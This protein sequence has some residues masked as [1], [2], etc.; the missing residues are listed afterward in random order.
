MLYLILNKIMQNKLKILILLLSI[1]LIT[2]FSCDILKYNPSEQDNYHEIADA[3]I[4]T[5]TILIAEN[6]TML[7]WGEKNLN[8]SLDLQGKQIDSIICM[9]DS[10]IL[11]IDNNNNRKFI[12]LNSEQFSDG[13]HCIK[14]I[15]KMRVKSGNGSLADRF[16]REYFKV[17]SEQKFY[18][19]IVNYLPN[20][21][22]IQQMGVESGYLTIRWP[23]YSK[24]NFQEYRIYYGYS[25]Y[26]VKTINDCSITMYQD[27]LFLGGL[28]RYRIDIKVAD[29]IVQGIERNYSDEYPDINFISQVDSH[30]IEIKWNTSKYYAAYNK[31]I[32]FRRIKYNA[33]NEIY[34]T[35]NIN[36]TTF[37]DSIFIFGTQIQYRLGIYRNNGTGGMQSDWEDN[38]FTYGDTL[39]SFIDIDYIPSKNLI[40]LHNERNGYGTEIRDGTTLH[41]VNSSAKHI[42]QDYEGNRAFIHGNDG[43]FYE[44]DPVSLVTINTFNSFNFVGYTSYVGEIAACENGYLFYEGALYSSP[45]WYGDATFLLNVDTGQLIDLIRSYQTWGFC[46][47]KATYKTGEYIVLW[48]NGDYLYKIENNSFVRMNPVEPEYFAFYQG[49]N[50]YIYTINTSIEIRNLSDNSLI[51]SFSIEDPLLKPTID[52]ATGYLGGYTPGNYR[53]YDLNTGTKIKEIKINGGTY[54]LRN[55]ILFCFNNGYYYMKLNY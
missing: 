37:I 13:I 40:Y 6:D 50:S 11:F 34:E 36:D 24:Q 45:T 26:L 39:E 53:I 41:L 52:P 32:L 55:S 48:C 2:I 17:V 35:Y 28:C 9:L 22:Q 4:D 49:H 16:N 5:T 8:Y 38:E 23:K 12:R 33:S 46:R 21:I 18:I 3:P 47:I 25:G 54:W 51:N 43:I 31:Y 44:I 20:P 7:V 1:S 19:N 10:T 14:F 27:S 15:I 29:K 30:K 42:F